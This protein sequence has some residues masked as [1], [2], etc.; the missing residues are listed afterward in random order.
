[1]K[2]QNR[3]FVQ[4][5]HLEISIFYIVLLKYF[6]VILINYLMFRAESYGKKLQK[7]F[8]REYETLETCNSILR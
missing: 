6:E 8:E 3:N 5:M 7:E 2:F 4:K 1:M